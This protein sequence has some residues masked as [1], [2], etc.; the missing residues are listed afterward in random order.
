MAAGG[1]ADVAVSVW[2]DE[3]TRARDVL[4][5]LVSEGDDLKVPLEAV[6]VGKLV[7]CDDLGECCDFGHQLTGQAFG[8]TVVLKNMGR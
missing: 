8:R 6:G 7:V 1:T 4:H 5:V 3:L 2:L